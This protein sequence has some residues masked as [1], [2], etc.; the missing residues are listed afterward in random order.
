MT[1]AMIMGAEAMWQSALKVSESMVAE[2]KLKHWEAVQA[3]EH[4]RVRI[5]GELNDDGAVEQAATSTAV[6]EKT[7]P[8]I[9]QRI[10][11]IIEL[12]RELTEL[13]K[14]AH[15]KL[16]KAL[17]ASRHRDNALAQYRQ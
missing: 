5:F 8:V 4:E 17:A 12:D 10:R 9:E 2:A 7:R 11:Q 16:A 3:L 14:E 15:A 6:T 1:A 13:T